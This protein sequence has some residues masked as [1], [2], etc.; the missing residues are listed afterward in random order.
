MQS[1]ST[2]RLLLDVMSAGLAGGE[3]A[4][5]PRPSYACI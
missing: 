1:K 3:E 5:C 2:V 4:D